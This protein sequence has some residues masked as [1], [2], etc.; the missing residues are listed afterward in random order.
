MCCR[1]SDSQYVEKVYLSSHISIYYVCTLYALKT[2]S[3][4]SVLKPTEIG[5]VNSQIC[6]RSGT[7]VRMSMIFKTENN[8]IPSVTRP[9]LPMSPHLLRLHMSMTKIM[10]S[11]AISAVIVRDSVSIVL[12]LRRKFMGMPSSSKMPMA[13]FKFVV[14]TAIS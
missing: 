7:L 2:N 9:T 1:E 13:I 3:K 5:S 14:R 4:K 12:M 8:I 6:G 10:V 11:A